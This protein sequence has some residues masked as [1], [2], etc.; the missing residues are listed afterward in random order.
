MNPRKGAYNRLIKHNPK[1][2]QK[3]INA[4]IKSNQYGGTSL[5]SKKLPISVDRLNEI[6]EKYAKIYIAELGKLLVAVKSYQH[7]F[8]TQE[9]S[10]EMNRTLY[11]NAKGPQHMKKKWSEIQNEV[12]QWADMDTGRYFTEA[13]GIFEKDAD[14]FN[15]I[16]KEFEKNQLDGIDEQYKGATGKLKKLESAA[17]TTVS[18]IVVGSSKLHKMYVTRLK[19]AISLMQTQAIAAARKAILDKGTTNESYVFNDMDVIY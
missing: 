17:R 1:Q 14:S 6:F 9:L 5:G 3:E 19:E 10:D 2:L 8:S 18:R 12:M 15:K 16:I 4:D 7:A 13:L 11:G